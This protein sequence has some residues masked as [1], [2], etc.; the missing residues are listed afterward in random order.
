[1]NRGIKLTLVI[2]ERMWHQLKERGFLGRWNNPLGPGGMSG[3]FMMRVEKDLLSQSEISVKAK[4][5]ATEIARMEEEVRSMKEKFKSEAGKDLEVVIKENAISMDSAIGERSEEQNVMWEKLK[6]QY[7]RILDG[8][9]P[10]YARGWLTGP[11]TKKEIDMAGMTL[12]ECEV[13]LIEERK[14]RDEVRK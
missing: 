11:G 2:P 13:K 3:W 10:Q 1:M 14:R 7:F 8:N 12:A 6:A 5:C 9:N 4:D